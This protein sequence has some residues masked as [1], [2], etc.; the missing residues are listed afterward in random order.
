MDLLTF[1]PLL[2]R[3]VWGGRRL[4]ELLGKPLGQH[5][6][7]AESWEI[8][9]HGTDQ[10]IVDRGP[11]A[12]TSLRQLLIERPTELLGR[13]AAAGADG[14]PLLL[15]FLDCQRVL[16]VQVHPN[17][18]EARRLPMPDRGKTE[19]WYVVAA[20]PESRIYAGLLPGVDAQALERAIAQGRCEECLHV[21]HPR[22][23]D[24]LFIPAGTVHALG[25]GLVVA[26]IQQSSDTTFRLFD[27]NRVDANGLP[28]ELHVRQALAVTDFRRGPVLPQPPTHDP[29]GLQTLVRCHAFV[30][31]LANWDLPSVPVTSQP[32]TARSEPAD[33]A[34]EVGNFLDSPARQH[35]AV[36]GRP[37][38]PGP[39][40]LGGD[41]RMRMVTVV[42][43]EVTL[44]SDSGEPLTLPLGGSAILPAAAGSVRATADGPATLLIAQLP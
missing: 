23:G 14:F 21:L 39:I 29:D 27:W 15:K 42:R 12:G 38:S 40:W 36:H 26:E 22:P 5:D 30:L 2:K 19:A 32:D 18:D 31:R 24:C 37:D 10:S 34:A 33:E 16:S 4:G 6:D 9:D 17:D 8:V 3:L 28:R 11:L 13:D 20:N 41:D 1:T 7:Y 44:Q 35:A 43:G 25:E